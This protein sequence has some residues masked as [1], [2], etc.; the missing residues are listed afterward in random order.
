MKI[1]HVLELYYVLRFIPHVFIYINLYLHALL[2]THLAENRN[3]DHRYIALRIRLFPQCNSNCLRQISY[4]RSFS[5][6][7]FSLFFHVK[8]IPW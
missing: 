1:R 7:Y 3:L 6:H 2:N 8:E 5:S 4:Y